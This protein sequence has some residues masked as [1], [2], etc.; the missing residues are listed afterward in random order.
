MAELSKRMGDVIL[1][2]IATE[3]NEGFLCLYGGTPGDTADEKPTGP[4]LAILRFPALAFGA[5]KDGSVEASELES[6]KDALEM[7]T[8]TWFRVLDSRERPV[9]MGTVGNELLMDNPHI[10]K[11]SVVAVTKL[12]LNWS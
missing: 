8:A 12:T 6:E 10:E 3:C 1:D 11:H 7:G 2:A 9:F 4:T 5:V